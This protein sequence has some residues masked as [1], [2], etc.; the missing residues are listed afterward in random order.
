MKIAVR[1]GMLNNTR[2]NNRIMIKCEMH[3]SQMRIGHGYFVATE[4]CNITF[5]YIEHMSPVDFKKV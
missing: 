2:E 3:I 1:H 4:K 5:S